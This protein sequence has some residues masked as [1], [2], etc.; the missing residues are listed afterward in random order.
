MF[1]V[2]GKNMRVVLLL[3]SGTNILCLHPFMRYR[4]R[5]MCD[6]IL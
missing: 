1:T 2:I 3:N 4:I 6:V 5:A